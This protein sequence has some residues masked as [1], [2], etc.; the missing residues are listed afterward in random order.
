MSKIPKDITNLVNL[1]CPSVHFLELDKLLKKLDNEDLDVLY[2]IVEESYSAGEEEA[3]GFNESAR[4]R[5]YDKGYEDG[6]ADAK[7]D[8]PI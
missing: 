8:G 5:G 7:D 6:Y 3:C 2:D 4:Q 1:Y